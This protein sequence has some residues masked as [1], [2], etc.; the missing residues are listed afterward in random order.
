MTEKMYATFGVSGAGFKTSGFS[1]SAKQIFRLEMP[2]T[3]KGEGIRKTAK[4]FK[5]ISKLLADHPDD[6]AELL[7]AAKQNRMEHALRI[8]KKVGLSEHKFVAQEG[9]LFWAVVGIILAGIILGYA[10]SKG[11]AEGGGTGGA[12]EGGQ[13]DG[14]VP[15]EQR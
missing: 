5:M 9:G 7:D 2:Q 12:G 10:A 3:F 15:I 6:M 13:H 14:G 1:G 8:A 11:E 4:D